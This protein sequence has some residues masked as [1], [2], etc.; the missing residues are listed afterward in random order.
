[1]PPCAAAG[2]ATMGPRSDDL[3]VI[4]R[5]IDNRQM[6]REQKWNQ[7]REN[8]VTY[9][10]RWERVPASSSHYQEEQRVGRWQSRQRAAHR[11]GTMTQERQDILE[12]IQGWTWNS[13]PFDTQ[14][15]NWIAQTTRLGRA[16][17]KRSTDVDEKK[18]AHWRSNQMQM[19]NMGRMSRER[20]DQL[21]N[22]PGW[23]WFS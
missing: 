6:S 1:V 5:K 4:H 12:T 23:T 15:N 2:L 10:T 14:R 3:K 21:D 9:Y 7:Q 13:D 11:H 22:T 16:P 19:C 18:A 20:M 8:W 17:S